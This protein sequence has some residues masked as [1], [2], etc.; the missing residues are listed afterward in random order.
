MKISKN[1]EMFMKMARYDCMILTVLKAARAV[2]TAAAVANALI[3][4]ICIVINLKKGLD[5]I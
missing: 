2:L 5:K 4:G 1:A 3:S